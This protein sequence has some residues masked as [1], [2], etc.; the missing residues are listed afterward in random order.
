MNG[1][2]MGL[3][4]AEESIQMIPRDITLFAPKS[5]VV[6]ITSQKET[7]IIVPQQKLVVIE[8]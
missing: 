2:V 6:L 7:T 1:I 5:E 8:V 4:F 3:I